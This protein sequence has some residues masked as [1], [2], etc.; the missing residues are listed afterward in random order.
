M[1]FILTPSTTSGATISATASGSIAKGAP[2][3][4]NTDG[5][6]SQVGLTSDPTVL[7]YGTE[8]T[9]TTN[10]NV[11][12]QGVVY[13]ASTNKIVFIYRDDNN[14][15]Y[16]T[17]IV[18]T[19]SGTSI[20]FGTP[21][22]F[23]S[24]AS[25]YM[26]IAG[27]KNGN[28]LVTYEVP[29]V[30]Y[31]KVGTISGTSISFGTRATVPTSVGY[32]GKPGIAYDINSSKYAIF[33][34]S[35]DGTNFLNV[36]L[37]TVSGT[38]VSFDSGT[39]VVVGGNNVSCAYD[40][41]AKKIAFFYKLIASGEGHS[42]V[43]TISGSSITFGTD[44][45]FSASTTTVINSVYDAT[46]LKVIVA[47]NSGGSD[48]RI[49][50]G[51]ISG[52]SISFGTA[53]VF[54]ST[55]SLYISLAYNQS[56]TK[57]IVSFVD[58]TT[59]AGKATIGTVSGTSISIGTATQYQTSVAGNNQCFSGSTGT[60]IF[61]SKSG[62]G[63]A[64]V[65]T[66]GSSTNLTSTNYIGISNAATT[67]GQTATVQVISSLNSNQTSLSIGKYYYVQKDGTLSITAD[68][69]SV[70]AGIS[71]SATSILIKG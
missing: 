56:T 26:N 38:T 31:G 43:G 21:V 42:V 22:V 10:P 3:I 64:I 59:S 14:S 17:A 34:Q 70:Y 69:P 62:A 53:V 44:V 19:V 58:G 28:V 6:V 35:A 23:E 12:W 1:S 46:N 37:G 47:Y 60:V 30:S 68:S 27:D 63:K 71:I 16:A 8:A 49:A 48:C 25:L 5:T 29:N 18:G 7:G 36:T 67:T 41:N 55:N 15:G 50:V 51:T 40:E 52:T 32:N 11:S 54:T 66:S 20:S 65:T 13:D 4:I 61:Y 57:I 2:I 33:W 39:N 9:T 24:N 45:V